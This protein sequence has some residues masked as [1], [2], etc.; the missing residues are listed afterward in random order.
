VQVI[1]IVSRSPMVALAPFDPRR[2]QTAARH[3][4]LA[5]VTESEALLA[6]RP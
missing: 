5:E 4:S 3:Y 6:W 2:F 1:D